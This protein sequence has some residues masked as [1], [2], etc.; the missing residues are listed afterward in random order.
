MAAA[1]TEF[2]EDWHDAVNESTSVDGT[3]HKQ[4]N[5]GSIREPIRDG[6]PE[7]KSPHRRCSPCSDIAGGKD[8]MDKLYNS[9]KQCRWCQQTDMIEVRDKD[10]SLLMIECNSCSRAFGVDDTMSP[11]V[12]QELSHHQVEMPQKPSST[13]STEPLDLFRSSS[14]ESL[15]HDGG[16]LGSKLADLAISEDENPRKSKSTPAEAWERFGSTPNTDDACMLLQCKC[17]PDEKKIHVIRDSAGEVDMVACQ[18]CQYFYLPNDKDCMKILSGKPHQVNGATK[19]K[20]R[21]SQRKA[22]GTSSPSKA[23]AN[24]KRILDDLGPAHEDHTAGRLSTDE[25]VQV[26]VS[27]TSKNVGEIVGREL[28]VHI[29]GSEAVGVAVGEMIGKATGKGLGQVLLKTK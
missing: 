20:K 16:R 11:D 26:A 24:V 3:K 6:K 10:G 28:D 25:F 18:T 17:R 15:T 1:S 29:P 12:K 14:E 5:P 8:A 22:T 2:D 13:A 7:S 21:F 23:T 27:R 9:Y 19:P 4:A